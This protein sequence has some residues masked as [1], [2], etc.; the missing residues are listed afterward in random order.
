MNFCKKII[1]ILAIIL[2]FFADVSALFATWTKTKLT[3]NNGVVQRVIQLPPVDGRFLTTSYK[4][5]KGEFKYFLPENT[6]FQF[7]MNGIT[8]SGNSNW[9]LVNVRLM[10]GSLLA[11][12]T[13]EQLK[14]NGF[15][16]NLEERYSG[17]LI[18]IRKK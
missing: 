17:E 1:L 6:D 15:E 13:G 2:L 4:P 10:D 18:E 8:Y 12:L 9:N 11:N 16:L 5:V 3:L 14:N 7:E